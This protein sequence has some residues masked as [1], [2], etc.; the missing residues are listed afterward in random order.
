MGKDIDVA[1]ETS[2]FPSTVQ[3]RSFSKEM[4]MCASWK[5]YRDFFPLLL[6][7]PHDS[8]VGLEHHGGVRGAG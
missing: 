4:A 2:L 7:L 1:M 6:L 8:P 3:E 5:N